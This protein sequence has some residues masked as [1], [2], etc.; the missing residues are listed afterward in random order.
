[1]LVYAGDYFG[2]HWNVIRSIGILEIGATVAVII[3]AVWVFLR[4]RKRSLEQSPAP[5]SS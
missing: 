4:M 3:A 1:V 5:E 2:A